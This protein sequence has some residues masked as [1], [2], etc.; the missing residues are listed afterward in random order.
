MKPNNPNNNL[1]L[2]KIH[3]IGIGGIG[4]SALARYFY[5]QGLQISGSDKEDSYMITELKKE[6]IREIWTPQNKEKI[7][8][9]NPDYIIYTTAINKDN[10]ELSWAKEN[11]KTI[12]HRS[13]ML[14]TAIGQKR[15]ISVSGTHGKTTTTAMIAQMLLD[16]DLNPSVILGGILKNENTNAISGSGEYFLIEA[17]ESDR[18]HL[19]GNPEIAI[20]TS[21]EADHLENYSNDFNEIKKSFIEFSK[22]A[23]LNQ[24]I[25]VCFDDKNTREIISD[26]FNINDKKIIT[27]GT[28]KNSK[29][30]KIFADF[31]SDLNSWDIFK[32]SKHITSL[33]LKIP[34]KHNILNS[35]AAFATGIL[36]GLSP[37]NIKHSLERY[38]GVKRRFEIIFKSKDLTIIDDY[39]HHPTEISATISA[40]KELNPHRLIIILQPHQPTRLQDLWEDFVNVFRTEESLVFITETYIARGKGIEGITTKKLVDEINKPN[41]KYLPGSIEQI[42]TH[43]EKVIKSNDLILI[44][45]AGDITTL[46][47]ALLSHYKTLAEVFGNN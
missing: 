33:K 34:G 25:I 32:D 47:K 35:L 45:G 2:K 22:K 39:A 3:F 11:N 18:S 16:H 8:A 44:M 38:E 5:S 28:G 26:N 46:G 31:N 9:H 37:K 12:L 24:G 43:L 4:M 14:E 20:I 13:E 27:Y 36:I 40:A 21:I 23:I 29:D 19:K 1:K 41:I 42:A 6:G 30:L 15:L 7:R 10:E 17:D